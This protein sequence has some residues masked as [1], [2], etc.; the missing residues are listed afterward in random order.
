[1]NEDTVYMWHQESYLYIPETGFGTF[2]EIDANLAAQKRT[3]NP[4]ILK[5]DI[6]HCSTIHLGMYIVPYKYI[7]IDF[8]PHVHLSAGIF[9]TSIYEEDP[10]KCAYIPYVLSYG[11][12]IC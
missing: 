6:I 8:I 4:N 2:T 12:H 7:N 9:I 3:E 1:M 11:K 10:S 5:A